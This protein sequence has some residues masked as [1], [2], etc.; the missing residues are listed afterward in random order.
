MNSVSAS[1]PYDA[2]AGSA[3]AKPQERGLLR[4]LRLTD[5]V[6]LF[7]WVIVSTLPVPGATPLRYMC[8]AYFTAGTVLYA[9]Q[10]FP[11]LARSWP[12]LILP[13]LCV[14]SALWAP[15]ANEAIR[16][17]VFLFLSMA[18]SAYLATRLDGRSIITLYF[19]GEIYG[20]I[21]T[22]M[23]PNP[24]DGVWSGP[25]G[26]KNYLA[27][28]MFVLFTTGL[29]LMLDKGANRWIRMAA[30]LFVGIAAFLIFKSQ[31]ATTLLMLPCAGVALL[32]HAY[33]W[34]PAQRVR[35]AR[36]F[37]V[38]FVGLLA[39]VAILLAFGLFQIDATEAVLKA[40][41]KDST[42]TGRTFIWDWGYRIMNEHPWT[43][44]GANGFWRP[45]VGVANQITKYFF[46]ENFVQFSFHN[47]YLEN[48]VQFGYPGY[49]ATMFVAAW[50]LWAT[51]RNWM[52]NQT[53]TNGA[54]LIIA[55]LI[56]IRSNTEIDLAM[57]LGGTFILFFVAA[58]R[59]D[60]KTDTRRRALL[61]QPA[62]RGLRP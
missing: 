39:L 24:M 1:S 56:V 54:F 5:P 59:R 47:S 40:F 10:T 45:E 35:H 12:T 20:A 36:T 27:I 34:Q 50:A 6:I 19:F 57:E 31:S 41:G 28:H 7:V 29:V 22:L 4:Y 61:P 37:L 44:V 43:G 58:M 15:S 48:G 18:I 26:Q 25:Y 9:R 13:V 32:V 3:P 42:L 17:S 52:R 38:M 21:L 23:N 30:P 62:P 51:A 46:F 55:G 11:V 14:I 8:V 60:D 49:Y 53:L 33:L 16:K 2:A